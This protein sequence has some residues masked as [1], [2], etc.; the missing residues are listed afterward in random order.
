MAHSA[1]S[2]FLFSSL[3]SSP[4]PFFQISFPFDS[5]LQIASQGAF[6]LSVAREDPEGKGEER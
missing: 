5:T 6:P 4:L 1:F 2:S 3:S